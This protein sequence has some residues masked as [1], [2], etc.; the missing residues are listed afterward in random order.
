MCET[1][2]CVEARLIN[3]KQI[4]IQ[5]EALQLA[6]E[7]GQWVAIYLNSEGRLDYIRADLA[8]GLPVKGYVSPDV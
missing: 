7:I 3:E 2:R 1:A 4:K 6:N 8:Q 5:Q